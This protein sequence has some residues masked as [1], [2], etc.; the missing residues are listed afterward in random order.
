MESIFDYHA[1]FVN[2]MR[3]RR[4]RHCGRVRPIRIRLK[5]V[6]FVKFLINVV[7]RAF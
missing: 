2:R 5:R 7:I 6:R 4:R 3:P 1:V